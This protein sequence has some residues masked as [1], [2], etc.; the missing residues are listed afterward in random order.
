MTFEKPTAETGH[1]NPLKK[2]KYLFHP[3]EIGFAGYK[4]SGKTT[5][6]CRLLTYMQSQYRIAYI[7]R[8]AHEFSMDHSGKDTQLAYEA[9]ATSVMISNS[10]HAA[11]HMQ[12]EIDP[13]LQ[14]LQFSEADFALI[15]GHKDSQINKFLLLD[16]NHQ[17]LD[18][19]KEG[20]LSGVIGVAGAQPCRPQELPA[21]IPYWHRDDISHIAAFLLEHIKDQWLQRPLFGLVLTGGRSTRMREDKALIRYD[22]CR[23]EALRAFELLDQF[24][25]KTYLSSRE[26]QWRSTEL[27]GL[28]T[29]TDRFLDMGPLSGI[30]SAMQQEPEASWLVLACDLPLLNS[31]VIN[32]L[33]D[34]RNPLA[35]ATAFR[36]SDH[37]LPEP[38]C[39]IYEPKF[40]ARL[41]QLLALGY[42]CPRKAMLQSRVNLIDLP[43]PQALKNVNY[44]EERQ[45][46]IGQ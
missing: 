14:R 33:L 46:L 4:N 27:A 32:R 25:E 18:A 15:E 23:P 43:T 35:N 38:L 10:R 5:L 3:T 17:I 45:Q 39:A 42:Q 16:D 6:I 37:G 41:L 31:S 9:G 13:I 22:G 44:P 36:A 11:M 28:R 8:D 34:A 12:G 29:I 26:G 21:S 24:C 20:Q 19:L 40:Y 7:K 2:T 1:H 30:L